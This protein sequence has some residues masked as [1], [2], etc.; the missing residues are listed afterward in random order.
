[1]AAIWQ[2]YDDVR[3]LTSADVKYGEL[4]STEGVMGMGYGHQSRRGFGGR[5]SA[6]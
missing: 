1:M 2:A 4:L 6:R 3:L 5:G